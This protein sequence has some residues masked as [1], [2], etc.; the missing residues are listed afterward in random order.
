MPACE[1]YTASEA[2]KN[3][4]EVINTAIYKG[5]VV[6]TRGKHSVAV[7]PLELLRILTELE[8]KSDVS[9]AKT[10]LLEFEE[11]GGISLDALKNELG[12]D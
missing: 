5:P 9:E 1:K 11:R 12:I 3:L 8:A 7:I 2:R 4:S 6:I 10:A